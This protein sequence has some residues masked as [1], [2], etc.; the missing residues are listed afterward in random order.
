MTVKPLGDRVV[1]KNVEAEETTKSGL[2]LAGTAK[3]KPQMAEVIAVGPGGNVDGKEI[4]M[5]VSVGQKV[6]YSKYAGTEVKI[7]GEELI[8][9]RQND[10]LA[11]VE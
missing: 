7:D 6:I 3:E 5:Q 11:I 1:I 8:I 2:I 10:I 9:V 4:T